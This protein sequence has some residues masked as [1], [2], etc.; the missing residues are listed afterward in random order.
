MK[1]KRGTITE[2]WKANHDS[3]M[4]GNSKMINLNGDEK[5]LEKLELFFQAVIIIMY[6]Q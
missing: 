3:S 1:T 6:L 4:L 5:I 2:R